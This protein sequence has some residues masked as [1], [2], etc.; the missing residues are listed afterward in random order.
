MTLPLFSSWHNTVDEETFESAAGV[1]R[2]EVSGHMEAVA[3]E[4]GSIA[5]QLLH[6]DDASLADMQAMLKL[7]RDHPEYILASYC[8]T[9]AVA[10]LLASAELACQESIDQNPHDIG[11]YDSLG[12]VHLRMKQW[13]KAIADYNKA[14]DN[15]PDLVV[16]LYGR[17]V[18]RRGEGRCGRWERRHRRGDAR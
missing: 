5:N 9:A 6:L 16:S 17:G 2:L 13:D 4:Y 15:K 18:A 10:G 14:I 7:D 8:Y 12:Y 1:T 11:Q 3:D